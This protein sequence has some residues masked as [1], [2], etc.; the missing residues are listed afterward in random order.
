MLRVL[1]GL[2]QTVIQLSIS[3][4]WKRSVKICVGNKI[5]YSNFVLKWEKNSY[6]LLFWSN[7]WAVSVSAIAQALDW[8]RS[9][10]L[11]VSLRPTVRWLQSL[12]DLRM[13]FEYHVVGH[14]LIESDQSSQMW[15]STHCVTI[16]TIE[17]TLRQLNQL[18][19]REPTRA[20]QCPPFG[21]YSTSKFQCL[22]SFGSTVELVSP[23]SEVCCCLCRWR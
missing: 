13:S 12:S 9:P 21:M 4:H 5:L 14:K 7:T 23:F 18:G 20:D 10:R 8:E 6:S 19:S 17:H 22:G 16:R 1:C 3:C 15:T 2:R 11:L